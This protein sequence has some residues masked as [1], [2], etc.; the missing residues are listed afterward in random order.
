MTGFGASGEGEGFGVVG[1]GDATGEGGRLI[2][3]VGVAVV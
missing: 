1:E 3:A 2:V